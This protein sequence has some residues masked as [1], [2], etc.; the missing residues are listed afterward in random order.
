MWVNKKH[1]DNGCVY[2]HV[3]VVL[4]S[5]SIEHYLDNYKTCS[6]CFSVRTLI[7]GLPRKWMCM[8]WD[9]FQ[10]WVASHE[11]PTRVK[12]LLRDLIAFRK[13][14][15][16]GIS[17]DAG[18]A[19]KG[20]ECSGFIKVNYHNQGIEMIG[21]HQILRSRYVKSVVPNSYLSNLYI[22]FLAGLRV[23]SYANFGLYQTAG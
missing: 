2:L 5:H 21:L 23:G 15:S 4:T 22:S 20:K 8:V 16:Y 12:V 10:N 1:E 6:F 19:K 14:A 11:V 13:N 3:L 7:L 9:I 18:V 17:F